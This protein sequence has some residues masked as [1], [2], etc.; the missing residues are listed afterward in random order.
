[1]APIIEAGKVVEWMGVTAEAEKELAILH[2]VDQYTK[3][4]TANLFA[5]AISKPV[6]VNDESQPDYALIAKACKEK[7]EAT[8]PYLLQELG[9]LPK[10]TE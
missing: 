4:V 5:Q 3:M 9:L 6:G 7:A 2:A 8:T 10:E 1:M